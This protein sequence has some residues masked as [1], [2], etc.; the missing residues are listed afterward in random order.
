VELIKSGISVYTAH[1]NFDAADGGN[2][3]YISSLLKLK[4]I[5]KFG[6]N[7]MARA[8]ELPGEMS[9]EEVCGHVKESLGLE[10]VL[11]VGDPAAKIRKMGLCCGSGGHMIDEA[12]AMGCQA[13]L[14][15]DVK[16]HDAGYGAERGICLIDAGH[17]GTE[18]FFS[19]NLGEQLSAAVKGEVEIIS[20]LLNLEPFSIY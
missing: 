20:S 7:S 12:L 4:K 5:E 6:E 2:N 16:Y 17:Y 13:Y 8:G 15:G 10:R 11:A 18:K 14:T 19:E 9:F 1:T 3:D